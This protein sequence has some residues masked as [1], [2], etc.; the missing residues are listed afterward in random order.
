MNCKYIVKIISKLKADPYGS[1]FN[2]TWLRFMF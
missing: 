1:A 2:Y